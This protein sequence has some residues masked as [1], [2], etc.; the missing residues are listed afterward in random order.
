MEYRN[1]FVGKNVSV[2]RKDDRLFVGKVEKIKS[3]E[4]GALMTIRTSSGYKSVY[5][6]DMQDI[7]TLDD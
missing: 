5:M 7:Y 3:T 1:G 4:N 6:E 2:L